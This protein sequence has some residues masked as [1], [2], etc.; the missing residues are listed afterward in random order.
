MTILDEKTQS[1]FMTEAER[2]GYIGQHHKRA[3][4]RDSFSEIQDIPPTRIR[5]FDIE[6]INA[7]VLYELPGSAREKLGLSKK[8]QNQIEDRDRD[9]PTDKMAEIDDVANVRSDQDEMTI[10]AVE[11]GEPA[12]Y[13]DSEDTYITL[14][15]NSCPTKE[16]VEH[17]LVLQ[18]FEHDFRFGDLLISYDCRCCG[19]TVHWTEVPRG[20]N[21][22]QTTLMEKRK[23]VESQ[24]CGCSRELG[25]LDDVD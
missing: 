21:N 23:Y 14:I 1:F 5:H 9:C 12:D 7:V 19:A 15:F 20:T 17:A 25:S 16:I 11:W 10:Y 4:I 8:T 13:L 18:R 3:P 2:L 24:N 22:T 6:K